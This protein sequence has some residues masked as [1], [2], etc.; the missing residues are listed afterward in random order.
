MAVIPSLPEAEVTLPP[1]THLPE[2]DEILERAERH[3]HAVGERI[4]Q[5]QHEE[6]VVCE[7]DTVV[8]LKQAPRS[9]ARI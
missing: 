6:L 7:A 3:I 2:H 4:A 8:H 9:D 1:S 5:E